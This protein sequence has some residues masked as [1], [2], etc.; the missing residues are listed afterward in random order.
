MELFGIIFAAVLLGMVCALG[1]HQWVVLPLAAF[2][3]QV[4]EYAEDKMKPKSPG[5]RPGYE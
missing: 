1:I 2:V 3:V 4:R 5:V